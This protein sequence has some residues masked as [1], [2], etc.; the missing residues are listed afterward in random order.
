MV[1]G[2]LGAAAGRAVDPKSESM[3]LTLVVGE[4]HGVDETQEVQETCVAKTKRHLEV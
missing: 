2:G 4:T 1:V 3:S